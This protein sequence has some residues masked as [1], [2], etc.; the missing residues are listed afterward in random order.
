MTRQRQEAVSKFLSYVLRHHPEEIAIELDRAGWADVDKLLAGCKRHGRGITLDELQ[1]VV[2]N[3]DKQRFAFS[4][5]GRRIRA[6]QGHSIPV[7]LGLEPAAPPQTLYHGTAKRR[8]D[9]IRRHGLVRGSRQ[10]VHLSPDHETA[11]KVGR[12]YGK[13]VVLE[14]EAGRMHVDGHRFYLSDNG[15][16]LVDSVPPSY[17]RFPE[18]VA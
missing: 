3:N 18:S 14:V 15:V 10:Q 11:T 6:S 16:W 17:L 1:E 9:S 13:P 4:E 5:D 8:L 7:D 12:R 2:A